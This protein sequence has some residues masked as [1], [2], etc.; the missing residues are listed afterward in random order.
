M[1][2]KEGI[3][4]VAVLVLTLFVTIYGVNAFFSESQ[5]ND[6]CPPTLWEVEVLDE[7]TCFEMGGKWMK[8]DIVCVTT[9]CP[10]GYCDKEFSCREAYELGLERYHMNIFLITV[11]LGI[12][13]VLAGAYLFSLESVSGGIMAGG[14]GTILRG[15][16]SYWRYSEDWLRFLI[17]VIG[18][19][20][21]IYFA[22]KFQEK[23]SSNNKKLKKRKK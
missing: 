16:G 3:I 19:T 22:Y 5:Y 9:P 23:I 17:S 6:F 2:L 12:L 13:I 15:V 14:V 11:P 4:G 18:L 8:T 7:A 21:L 1:N 20:I 10:S